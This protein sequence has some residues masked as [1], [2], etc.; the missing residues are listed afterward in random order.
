M[1]RVRDCGTRHACATGRHRYDTVKSPESTAPAVYAKEQQESEP[2]PGRRAFFRR[3]R[4]G[5][6]ADRVPVRRH[7]PG[8][9]RGAHPSPLAV[10]ASEPLEPIVVPYFPLPRRGRR[11]ARPPRAAARRI[12]AGQPSPILRSQREVKWYAGHPAVPRSGVPARRPLPVPHRRA[13][14]SARG[15]PAE[16]ALL[17]I[18]E[19]AFDP[20]AYSHGR[21]AGLWQIIPGTGK[22]LGLAQNWWFDGRRDVARVDARRARLS[23]SSCTSSSTAIGCSPWRATTP[24]K[25]TSRAR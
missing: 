25:A 11:A 10:A 24:A 4:L 5:H 16:L 3:A 18:V 21:A 14:S 19:S 15:M 12:L 6:H 8:R 1:Q 7:P 17:P 9:A 20:F 22:R 2:E 23:R 13:S